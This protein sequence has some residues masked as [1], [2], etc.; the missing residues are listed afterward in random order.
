MSFRRFL[1][2]WGEDNVRC[3]YC[4]SLP[5]QRFQALLFRKG[6]LSIGSHSSVLHFAP[7]F[8]LSRVIRGLTSDYRS[9]DSL[10]SFIPGICCLPDT[11]IDIQNMSFE[12]AMFDFI[13]C[14][15]VLEHVLDDGQALCEL[16][17]CLKPDG[18]TIVTVPLSAEP[19]A[20]LQEG[21]VNTPLL[22]FKLYGS[23]DHLRLYGHDIAARFRSAGFQVRILKPSDILNDDE[24]SRNVLESNEVHF[25]LT[26][27]GN[28]SGAK[29]VN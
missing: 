17:R 13:I 6:I 14:N 25:L 8:S 20:T 22:R 21:W 28:T 1:P 4:N 15:H 27:Q 5:R 29:L 12:S 11:I 24:I 7:E 16:Y 10:A 26:K 18:C 3:P 2:F 23:E 9:A 19:T